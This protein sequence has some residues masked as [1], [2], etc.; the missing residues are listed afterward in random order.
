MINRGIL[1]FGLLGLL[2]VLSYCD[3]VIDPDAIKNDVKDPW[4][5]SWH[6]RPKPPSSS[7]NYDDDNPDVDVTE[8]TESEVHTVK[9]HLSTKKPKKKSTKIHKQRNDFQVRVDQ[10]TKDQFNEAMD[11]TVSLRI[12][13]KILVKTQHYLEISPYT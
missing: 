9:K 5:K 4:D 12:A 11:E 2:F 1:L 13:N 6:R 7:S 3:D 10:E 8:V